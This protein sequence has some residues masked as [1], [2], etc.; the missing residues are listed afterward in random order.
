MRGGVLRFD[1]PAISLL[2]G[3]L[4]DYASVLEQIPART[5]ISAHRKAEK[6][7]ADILRKRK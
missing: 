7:V 1:G 6:Y 5:M 3:V 2:R 4:E